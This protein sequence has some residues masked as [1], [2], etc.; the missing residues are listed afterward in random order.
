MKFSKKVSHINFDGMFRLIHS[1]SLG[2][3]P[4]GKPQPSN[5]F[6]PPQVL[7]NLISPPGRQKDL[8]IP[9][10]CTCLTITLIL[11]SEQLTNMS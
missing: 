5:F 2:T 11:I 4:P 3:D 6:C 9:T 1:V 7:K 10:C 8:K